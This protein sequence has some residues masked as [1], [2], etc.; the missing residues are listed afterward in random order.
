MD[1]LVVPFKERGLRGK[2][3]SA[4]PFDLNKSTKGLVLLPGRLA[5]VMFGHTGP[6]TGKKKDQAKVSL[7]FVEVMKLDC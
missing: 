5:S 7:S 4:P 3:G 6:T 2:A 1:D